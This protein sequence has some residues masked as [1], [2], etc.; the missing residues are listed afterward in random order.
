MGDAAVGELFDSDVLMGMAAEVGAYE[1]V[2]IVRESLRSESRL[3]LTPRPTK[4][5]I[6]RGPP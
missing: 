1:D 4:S 3:F 5:L 2:G 6:Q